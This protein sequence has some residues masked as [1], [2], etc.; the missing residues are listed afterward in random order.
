MNRLLSRTLLYYLVLSS[1][2]LILSGAGF[3]LLMEKLYLDDV[4]EAVFLRR[5][6]FFKNSQPSLRVIDISTWNR[7]N[8][9]THIL[10]ET[11]SR[12][13]DKII[14]EIFYDE[15]VPEWEPYRVLYTDIKIQKQ[16][17]VL[18][19][20]LN[21]VESQDLIIALTWLYLGVLMALLL[22]IFFVTRLISN[23]LWH[24]FYETLNK[25]EQFNIEQKVAPILSA[26]N[27][28]EFNQLNNAL[29]KLIGDNMKAYQM[30][31]EFT[32]NAS[33]E[34]QTPLAI[35]QS[36][37]DI[38]LQQPSLTIEQIIQSLYEASARL[39][40][41]NRN[42][43]LLS[44]IE[45]KQFPETEIIDMVE[46]VNDVLP[47]FSEQCLSNNLKITLHTETK[48]LVVE[49]NKGLCEIMI[50]NLILNAVSHNLPNGSIVLLLE[51]NK[52]T[53]SN[54]GLKSLDTATLF[55]R[56]SKASSNAHN[57]GLGL[58]IVEQICL[59]QNWRISYSF[60]NNAHLFSVTV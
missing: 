34:L 52:L 38:L 1:A 35:F 47:Y 11:L 16:P 18:M 3:Y 41:V 33:H 8:R 17:Y 36:K 25:I 26:G 42:L 32:E 22:V 7:F 5:D 29:D 23:K 10:P 19:I 46:I 49:A 45:N 40:R 27:I 12:P 53:I 39:S 59:L 28:A 9:D 30:Q 2:I 37:L 31:K 58:A 44:K 57:T 6:E 21:L 60:E 15:M 13:K 56:F 4:D 24:P 48:G 20:R 51:N 50:N 55:K 54:P 14:Q 43:L